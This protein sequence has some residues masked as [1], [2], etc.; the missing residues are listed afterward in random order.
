MTCTPRPPCPASTAS[1]TTPWIWPATSASARPIDRVL[2]AAE[3]AYFTAAGEAFWAEAGRIARDRAA[4]VRGRFERGDRV[5][6]EHTDDPHTRLRP[7][8]E[9]TVTRYDPGPASS[10]SAGTAEAPC[11]CS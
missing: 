11:P 9:G 8:D 2:A 5:A 10:T 4:Q 3:D 1:A 6:L 7:G